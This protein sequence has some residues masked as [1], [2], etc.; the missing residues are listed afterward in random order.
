MTSSKETKL[1]EKFPS[2]DGGV[3]YPLQGTECLNSIYY[4]CN[5]F[6][7]YYVTADKNWVLPI[8]RMHYSLLFSLST[9]SVLSACKSKFVFLEIKIVFKNRVSDLRNV[10]GA[11][12]RICESEFEESSRAFQ[13]FIHEIDPASQI[14]QNQ[15]NWVACVRRASWRGNNNH[16]QSIGD[17]KQQVLALPV[18]FSRSSFKEQNIT[19]LAL[20]DIRSSL[21]SRISGSN[22]TRY[23]H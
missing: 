5:L 23:S 17:T 9:S 22:I 6:N 12:G 11:V 18:L 13:R 3:T 20:L 15:V 14:F 2:K 7:L 10:S 1:Q 21:R 4:Y 16:T 19:V 8:V